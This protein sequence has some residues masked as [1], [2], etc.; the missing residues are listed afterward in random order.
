MPA[1][2]EVSDVT[3]E[4]NPRSGLPSSGTKEGRS[5]RPAWSDKAQAFRSSQDTVDVTDSCRTV[6]LVEMVKWTYQSNMA[7]R[8][9]A[10]EADLRIASIALAGT[11]TLVTGNVRHF[12][13]VPDLPIENWLE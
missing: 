6:Q 3:H 1:W 10:A 8:V 11:L 12:E 9:G 2:S 7:R 5:R 13:R 4:D